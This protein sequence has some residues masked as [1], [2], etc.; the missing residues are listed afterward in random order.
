MK[1]DAPNPRNPSHAMARRRFMTAAGAV[2]AG[3]AAGGA[4]ANAVTGA[5]SGTVGTGMPFEAARFRACIGSVFQVRSLVR[6]MPA[7]PLTLARVVSSPFLTPAQAAKGM[8]F[9]I[10]LAGATAPLAQDTYV[11]SHPAMREF[12]ALLV[13]TADGRTLVGVF[14]IAA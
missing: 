14:D 1:P 8:A 2:C 13:P 12:I 4:S 5:L 6:D 9:S 7:V 11:V 10:D 3:A